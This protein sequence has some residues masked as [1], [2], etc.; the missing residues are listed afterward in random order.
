[1]IFGHQQIILVWQ[2]IGRLLA[3]LII[4]HLS[5]MESSAQHTVLDVELD[6]IKYSDT[7]TQNQVFRLLR[8][9]DQNKK[10]WKSLSENDALLALLKELS[11]DPSSQVLTFL[12]SSHQRSKIN[13]QNPRAIYFSDDIYVGF[14]P[15]G[16]VELIVSDQEKGLVFYSF[17]FG[18]QRPTVVR[19]VNR[20]MT[21]HCSVRT[22]NI[23]GL[24]IRSIL[25]DPNGLPVYSAKSY[26]TNHASPFR[27]RWGGWYVTGSHGEMMHRGNFLLPNRKRPKIPLNFAVGQNVSDL[28]SRFNVHKYPN[29]HSDIVA[30]MVFEHQIDCH[31]LMMR[32]KYAFELKKLATEQKKNAWQTEADKLVGHFLFEKEFQL[33]S[34]VNGT[35]SFT[36]KFQ[37]KGPSDAEGNSLRVFDLK[38]RLFRYPCSYM[39][40]SDAFEHLPKGVR[41]YVLN[42]LKSK[43]ECKLKR[44]EQFEKI[45]YRKEEIIFSLQLVDGILDK[46]GA[47]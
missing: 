20:C 4:C 34:A 37:R 14:V 41:I 45:V 18:S 19:E 7:A 43:L 29:K 42:R 36:E 9:I 27:E 44:S 23:P 2:S 6:P 32:A 10:N 11:V 22:M 15:G 17:E 8:R 26:R 25:P 24:Q 46:K 13:P 16:F 35:S 31:N 28:S 47:K 21:C 39:I 12:K 1:M 40:H 5:V 30:L 3:T 33:T 38:T